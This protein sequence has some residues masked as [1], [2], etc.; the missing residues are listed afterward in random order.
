MLDE[1]PIGGDGP[2]LPDFADPPVVEVALGIQFDPIDRLTPP[3]FG[4]LW[5]RY[6]DRYPDLQVHEARSAGVERF[7]IP[8]APAMS[9]AIEPVDPAAAIRAWFVNETGTELI[10]VQRDRFAFNWRRHVDTETY[11]RY[12]VVRTR[13]VEHLNTFVA[14]LNDEGL[15][16]ITP[17]QCEATYL[18]HITRSGVW[19]EH[20]EVDKV[21][22]VWENTYSDDFLGPPEDV[23]FAARYVLP[24]TDGEPIGR[25]R[26]VLE[27]GYT[28]ADRS[29]IFVL[30]LTA[31]GEPEEHSIQGSLDFL[32]RA[33][34]W[35]VR[36]FASVTE[37]TMH[38]VW[39]RKI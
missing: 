32:D 22:T 33:R 35:I 29:P 26:I 12:P 19:Q 24:G 31:R 13:F 16:E 23:R 9:L 4:L 20:G 3:L 30:R 2:H 25:L 38:Q 39:G 6:R 14:F 5:S 11:P 7:G 10:Q 36:A 1:D 27:P 28:S 17:N 37:P 18:N 8:S 15:G 34:K 21:V